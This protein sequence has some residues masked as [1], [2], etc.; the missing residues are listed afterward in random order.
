M[1]FC[2]NCGAQL[3][4]GNAFC[5]SCGAAAGAKVAVTPAPSA[6]NTGLASNMAG[7]LAYLTFIPAIVFLVVEPYKNDKFIRFHSFQSIFYCVA[8]IAFSIAWTI[9][10]VLLGLVSMGFLAGLMLLLSTIIHLAFLCFWIF[11]VYKAYQN[12]YFRAPFIGDLAAKQA[13]V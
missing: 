8:L 13:G 12:E 10:S 4:E 11:L 2:A 5:V 1:A 9:L 6:T 7:A 3:A